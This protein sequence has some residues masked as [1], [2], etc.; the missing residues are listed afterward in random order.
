[1]AAA[2]SSVHNRDFK[3]PH[4]ISIDPILI[5]CGFLGVKMAMN[6]KLEGWNCG[7]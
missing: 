5:I 6:W 4:S 2:D 3:N 7:L 1:V